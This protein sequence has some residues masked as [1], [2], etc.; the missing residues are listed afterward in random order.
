AAGAMRVLDVAIH[1]RLPGFTLAVEF[2][3]RARCAAL[4]GPSGSGKTMTL[5]AIAGAF[6]PDAGRIALDGHVW[7]DSAAG[8]WVPPQDRSVGYGP[9]NSALF[10]HRDVA[11]NIGFGLAGPGSEAGRRRIAR[12]IDLVQLHGL[13]RR[14]PAEL[15]GG[16]QQRVAL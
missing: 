5:R 3:T 11:G 15:S 14:R 8:R 4:V 6:R 1:R 2:T 9:Q 7:Y 12:M 16:Q 10:P 13:E